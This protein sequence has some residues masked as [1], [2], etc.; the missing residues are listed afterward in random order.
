MATAIVVSILALAGFAQ[1]LTGFGFGLVSMALLPLFI[2]FKD[3]VP[4]VAVL[5]LLVCAA[6]LLTAR[7]H[8]DWRRV[9]P[10][11]A[12]SAL[13]VPFGVWALVRWDARWLLAV[14]GAWMIA[15]AISELALARWWRPRFPEWSAWPVGFISGVLGGAFNAGGPPVIAYTYSQPWGKEET[16]AALQMV[17]GA[18][19][20]VRVGFMGGAGLMP[21]ELWTVLGAAVLPVLA[22]IT[23]GTRLLR[24]VPGAALKVVAAAFF[25]VMGLKYLLA[26]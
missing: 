7:R 6:T 21:A 26:P 17:F 1:G 4:L 13:G 18:S 25:L 20:V 8:L 15:F 16:V 12:A 24:R 10:L 2:D 22:G 14:L 19:A 3:A 23:L 9:A 11:A 5:N